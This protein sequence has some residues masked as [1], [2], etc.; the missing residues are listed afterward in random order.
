MSEKARLPLDAAGLALGHLLPLP[1]LELLLERGSLAVLFRQDRGC[2]LMPEAAGFVGQLDLFRRN[3]L[4]DGFERV[5]IDEKVLFLSRQ[6]RTVRKT[7]TEVKRGAGEHMT[8]G[9]CKGTLAQSILDL[10]VPDSLDSAEHITLWDIFDPCPCVV[11]G[12]VPKDDALDPVLGLSQPSLF[13]VVQDDLYLDL[14]AHDVTGIC[15]SH[16]Q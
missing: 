11:F 5:Q 9:F 16:A 1:L 15:H 12:I 4:R 8:Y 7:P 2:H 3:N 14:G 10:V 13:H 6:K